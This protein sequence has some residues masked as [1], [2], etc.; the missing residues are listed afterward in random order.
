MRDVVKIE[1]ISSVRVVFKKLLWLIFVRKGKSHKH[2][3]TVTDYSITIKE[4]VEKI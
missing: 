2:I 4:E 1:V 3:I